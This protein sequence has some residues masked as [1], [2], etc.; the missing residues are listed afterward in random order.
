MTK[1]Q[2]ARMDKPDLLFESLE[3]DLRRKKEVI[4]EVVEEV[5]VV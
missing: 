4:Q 5:K 1:K 2:I 3:Q